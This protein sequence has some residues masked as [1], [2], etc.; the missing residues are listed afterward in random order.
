M[1]RTQI[2]EIDDLISVDMDTIENNMNGFSELIQGHLANIQR[3]ATG[4][5]PTPLPMTEQQYLDLA[6]T[7]KEII[8][9]KDR[10]MLTIKLEL[11][12]YKYTLYKIYGL[13]SFVGS[14]MNGMDGTGGVE[15]TMAHNLEYANSEME[16]LFRKSMKKN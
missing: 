5:A 16:D 8:A 7:T 4:T 1:D 3:L 11:Q 9:E 13:T 15:D 12:E 2:D 14:I 6:N 10:K